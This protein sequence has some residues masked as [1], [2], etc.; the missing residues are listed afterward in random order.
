LAAADPVLA[1]DTAPALAAVETADAAADNTPSGTLT[2][3]EITF[4]FSDVC[5]QEDAVATTTTK[6]GQ[7]VCVW[8]L[9]GGLK[10]VADGDT[11]TRSYQWRRDGAAI[12]GATSV[13]YAPTAGDLGHSITAQVTA[14]APGYTSAVD[15]S[16]ALTV[17][18]G[19]IT[20]TSL[21]LAESPDPAKLYKLTY[22][23][24]PDATL[25]WQWLRD[26]TPI[27]G[28]TSDDYRPTAADDG[29]DLSVR[30]TATAP[31]YEPTSKVSNTMKMAS[32]Y[33]IAVTLEPSVPL[34]YTIPANCHGAWPDDA[35]ITY[36]WFRD[37]VA[38]PGAT[39]ETYRVDTADGGHSLTVQATAHIPG[40]GDLP[41]ERSNA[42]QVA[43]AQVA[44][45]D[46]HIEHS[47]KVDG[48]YTGVTASAMCTPNPGNA[49]LAYQW[50][51]GGT[52]IAGATGQSYLLTAADAGQAITVRVTG[53][54]EG[55]SPA[56]ATSAAVTPGLSHVLTIDRVNLLTPI[57][58]GSTLTPGMQVTAPKGL[59]PT[60]TWQWYRNGTAIAGA[61]AE[62]YTVVEADRGALL[63]V[64]LTAHL[65]GYADATSTSAALPVTAWSVSLTDLKQSGST[66]VL[67]TAGVVNQPAGSS[68]TFQ[69]SKNGA[70]IA[71][72]TSASYQISD[73]GQ[74]PQF[75]VRVTVKAADGT[76]VSQT[77]SITAYGPPTVGEMIS[78]I[79]DML[80]RVI[81]LLMGLFR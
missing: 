40:W 53:T 35:T 44:I 61:T 48:F 16:P 23:V 72:A 22:S 37:G 30:L 75:S 59:T 2:L 12:P 57:S 43:A 5:S 9:V 52:A 4:R 7:S 79:I 71:G 50:F 21:V 34:G 29:H 1:T 36:Q 13:H 69:W 33:S 6:V 65:D 51:R 46:L 10:S 28:A 15:T 76:S 3:P 26:G 70:A 67:M 14:S 27:P 38:I 20:I 66:D 19:Q 68:V 24:R 25:A 74:H 31:G 54:F 18:A 8:S 56:T 32:P 49:T 80:V 63:A 58:V 73:D 55:A 42:T 41:S 77:Q 81:N 45:N 11:V 47:D 62:K 78:R 60:Y 64:R 17:Q 39:A